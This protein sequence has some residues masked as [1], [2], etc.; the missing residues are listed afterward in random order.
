MS[1]LSFYQRF[2]GQF[3]E[4]VWSRLNESFEFQTALAADDFDK[5]GLIADTLLHGKADSLKEVK[6]VRRLEKL[7][8]DF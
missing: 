4:E 1:N 5:A 3:S 8:E 7:L 6:E 2:R